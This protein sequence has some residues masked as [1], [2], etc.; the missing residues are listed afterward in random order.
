MTNKFNVRIKLGAEIDL[1]LAR[2]EDEDALKDYM[3]TWGNIMKMTSSKPHFN[4]LT[5]T[6]TLMVE[7]KNRV[8]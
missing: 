6:I 5:S 1:Q 3:E 2:K 7:C 4:T 8:C